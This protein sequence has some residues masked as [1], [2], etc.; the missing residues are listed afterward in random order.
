MVTMPTLTPNL[1]PGFRV[2]H[3]TCHSQ[4]DYVSMPELSFWEKDMLTDATAPEAV[5]QS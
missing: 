5:E 1:L 3:W 4:G 2:W